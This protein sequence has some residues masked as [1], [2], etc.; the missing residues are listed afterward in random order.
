[1]NMAI[2]KALIIRLINGR[3]VEAS[4][5]EPPPMPGYGKYNLY[6]YDPAKAKQLLAK[7]GYPNGFTTTFYSDNIGDDPRISQAIVQQLA[8]IG[9][10]INLKV[11]NGNTWQTIVGTKYKA[12]MSWAAWF[13]DFPDPNDF[14]EPI[15]SCASA[16][17]GTFNEPWYCNPKVDRYAHQLKIMTNRTQRLKLYPK[18]DKMIMSDAPIVPVYYPVYYD[19]HSL[20]LHHY[21]VNGQWGWILSAY[22][23]S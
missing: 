7:A 4:T 14:V 2:N 20:A 23:K 19:L 1:M 10:K 3:G 9:V 12:P 16:A 8:Q 22:T 15:F 5:I 13:E 21:F 11:V 17:P 6:P 18:L